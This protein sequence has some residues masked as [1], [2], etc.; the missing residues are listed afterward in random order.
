MDNRSAILA[1]ATELLE[2]SPNGDIST[3]GVGEKA[4]VQQP[5]IYRLFGDKDSLLAAVVDHGFAE[6][7]EAKRA[8]VPTADPV[9]DLRRGWD[10]HTRFALDHPNVYRLMYTPRLTTP[11]QAVRDARE[12]LRGVLERV[13]QAGR[14]AVQPDRAADIVMA[15]N[16]GVALALLNR[17]EADRDPELSVRVR[18]IVLPGILTPE[19]GA[20]LTTT[21]PTV[22][23][24]ATTL[25]ALLRSDRPE[26]FSPAEFALLTEWLT[27]L[28]TRTNP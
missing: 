1:A 21:P 15:A 10:G 28:A 27:H 3:R 7:L 17:P 23:Q 2:T 25:G 18:D 12:L 6:Y 26:S 16:T 9:A 14:L 8:A 20:D 24:A 4:G 5:V 11:P 13:A 19:P 22:A